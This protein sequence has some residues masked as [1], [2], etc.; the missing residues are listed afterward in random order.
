MAMGYYLRVGDKTTCGGQI[1]SGDPTFTWYGVATALEG[2]V[3]SCGENP[4]V[5]YKILGGTLDT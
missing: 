1:L 2:S 4:G 5:S 3:V